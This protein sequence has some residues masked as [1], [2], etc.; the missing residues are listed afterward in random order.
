MAFFQQWKS[1]I[2]Q[3][4]LHNTV[5]EVPTNVLQWSVALLSPFCPVHLKPARWGLSLETVLPFHDLK[6]TV[7]FFVVPRFSRKRGNI[8]LGLSLCP[9]VRPSV[10][11]SVRLS[12]CRAL[13]SVL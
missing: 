4:V 1:N 8:N 2:V 13:V 11:P 5:A 3:K 12:V 10:C 7:F 6:P 9:S